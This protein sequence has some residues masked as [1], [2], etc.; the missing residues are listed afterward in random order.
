MT[1]EQVA[2]VFKIAA[3]DLRQKR[4]VT[5]EEWFSQLPTKEKA[6]V[7]AKMCIE[8]IRDYEWSETKRCSNDYWVRW[9][10][11]KHDE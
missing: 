2:K 1:E 9:L 10:K 6:N 8:A 4:K 7:L 3:E 5:N 11:E